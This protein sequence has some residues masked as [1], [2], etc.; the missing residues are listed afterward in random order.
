GTI[1][2]S[3]FID[4]DPVQAK[5]EGRHSGLTKSLSQL[6]PNRLV[7]SEVGAIPEGWAATPLA[8]VLEESRDEVGDRQVPEYSSTNRGLQLRSRHYKKSLA[9]SDAKNKVIRKGD[10]V[11]GLS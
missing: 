6:F 9:R 11:F 3:W 1:F 7:P 10:M 5:V 8:G 2:R 4:F